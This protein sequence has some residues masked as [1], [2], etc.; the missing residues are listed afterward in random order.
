MTTEGTTDAVHELEK[1][2][3]QDDS[4]KKAKDTDENEED[5]VMI[6]CRQIF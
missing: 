6:I 3:A 5:K 2:E 1:L 4:E